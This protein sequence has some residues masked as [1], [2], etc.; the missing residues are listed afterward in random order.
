M[1][2]PTNIAGKELKAFLYIDSDF[3]DKYDPSEIVLE[4][5]LTNTTEIFNIPIATRLQW[6]SKLET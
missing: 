6:N 1:L 5:T 3:N 4:K 2:R